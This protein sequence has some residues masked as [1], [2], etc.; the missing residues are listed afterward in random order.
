L[1]AGS[2]SGL[3]ATTYRCCPRRNC[4]HA[5]VRSHS[6][7]QSCVDVRHFGKTPRPVTLT[8]LRFRHWVCRSERVNIGA[9]LA[10]ECSAEWMPPWEHP[11]KYSMERIF[12]GT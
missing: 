9:D 12:T 5:I 11:Q 6:L 8:L 7:F 10:S 2:L 3:T 4:Q 1:K